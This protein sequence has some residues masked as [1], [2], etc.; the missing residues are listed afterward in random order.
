MSI[1]LARVFW[2]IFER[3]YM[4]ARERE[5]QKQLSSLEILNTDKNDSNNSDTLDKAA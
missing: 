5:R 2:Q 3:P 4:I 1:A